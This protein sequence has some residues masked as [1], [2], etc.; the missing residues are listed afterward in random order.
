M[1]GQQFNS[2]GARGGQARSL[3]ADVSPHAHHAAPFLHFYFPYLNCSSKARFPGGRSA[4]PP[5]PSC[6]RAS[7]GAAPA[8]GGRAGPTALARGWRA[9]ASIMERVRAC[10]FACTC[11]RGCVHSGRGRVVVCLCVFPRRHEDTP[12]DERRMKAFLKQ[13]REEGNNCAASHFFPGA[14]PLSH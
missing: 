12:A 2:T 9:G 11:F 6:R 8:D 1:C 14:G 5:A 7:P 10:V 3:P 4:P 13:W